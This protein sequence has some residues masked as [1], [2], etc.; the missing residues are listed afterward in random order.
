M[1]VPPW[2]RARRRVREPAQARASAPASPGRERARSSDE[3]TAARYPRSIAYHLERAAVAA[4]DLDPRSRELADRA[5]EALLHAGDLALDASDALAASDLYSR[6][7][8]SST[9]R[10]GVTPAGASTS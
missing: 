3:A 8:V 5:V 2:P 4:L 6:A 1:A 7:L 10:I 9:Q